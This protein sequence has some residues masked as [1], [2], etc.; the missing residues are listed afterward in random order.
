MPSVKNSTQSPGS[1]SSLATPADAAPRPKGNDGGQLNCRTT[2]WPRNSSGSGWPALVHSSTPVPSA[3]RAMTPVT[4]ASPVVLGRD[5]LIDCNVGRR[6]RLSR[7]S[8]MAVGPYRQRGHQGR[9]DPVAHAIEERGVKMV[10][11]EGVVEGVARYL[12]RRLE[13]PASNAPGRSGQ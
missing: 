10:V 9:F 7:P 11:V 4:N 6:Q 1:R 12:V 5:R 8:R 2:R 13:P 3:K